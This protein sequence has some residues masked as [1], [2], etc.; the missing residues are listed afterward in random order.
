MNILDAIGQ[1]GGV[2][3][4][5]ILDNVRYVKLTETGTEVVEIDLEEY[6]NDPTFHP[7]PIVEPGS[8]IYVEPEPVGFWGPIITTAITTAVTAYI[9]VAIRDNR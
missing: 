1:A 8:T 3:A 9:F 6:L 5:A 4:T 2:T 7:I